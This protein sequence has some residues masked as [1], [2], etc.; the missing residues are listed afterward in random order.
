M[1]WNRIEADVR[2]RQNDPD[3]AESQVLAKVEFLGDA[4]VMAKA[5]ADRYPEVRVIDGKDRTQFTF[6]Q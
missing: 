4:Y 3:S 1:K 5:I 6:R 2:M